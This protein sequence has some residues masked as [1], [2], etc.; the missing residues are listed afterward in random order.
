MRKDRTIGIIGAGFVGR[1]LLRLFGDCAIYDPAR[2]FTDREAVSRCRFAFVCVPTPTAP[3]GSCDT[4]LVEESVDWCGSD[5]IVIRSTVAPGTTDR[6]RERTGKRIVFQPEYIGET[7]AHPLLDHQAQGFSVL[8]GPVED[9]SPLADLYKRFYHA[10]HRF[11]F[12]SAICAELAK[13]MENSFYAVKVTFCNE[14]HD[15]ARTFGVDCNELRETWLAD[16]RIS[17]DHTFVHPDDRGFGGKCLPKDTSAII[18]AATTRGCEPPLLKTVMVVNAGYRRGDPA[19]APFHFRNELQQ[20]RISQHQEAQQIAQK[21]ERHGDNAGQD[22]VRPGPRPPRQKQIAD[23]PDKGIERGDEPS[24]VADS[25]QVIDAVPGGSDHVIEKEDVSR[26]QNSEHEPPARRAESPA[27]GRAGIAGSIAHA[28]PRNASGSTS[29]IL[30]ALDGLTSP[31]GAGAELPAGATPSAAARGIP[32]GPSRGFRDP[33]PI[34]NDQ[35][36][37]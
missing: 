17:R 27:V 1:A 23:I 18:A 10:N 24:H 33:D 19:Y 37:H 12:C 9:T 29:R 35:G 14:W 5:I 21:T 2:G 7:P 4:S 22:A 13:Y 6:L 3:D 26:R 31:R 15:I 8:G 34:G 32:M 36:D 25:R 11:H 28:R 16:P 30:P 20:T